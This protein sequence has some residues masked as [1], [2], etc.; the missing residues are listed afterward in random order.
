MLVILSLGE[1]SS[2]EELPESPRIAALR[3]AAPQERDGATRYFWDA[4]SKGGTP[5]VDLLEGGSRIRVT[6]VLRAPVPAGSSDDESDAA[7]R[8]SGLIGSFVPGGSRTL[9]RFERVPGTDVLQ[10]SFVLDARSRYRYYLAWPQGRQPDA[11]AVSRLELDGL[12][13]ELFADPLASRSFLDDF[14]GRAVRNSYFEGPS[15]PPEPWLDRRE[16]TARGEVT[17]LEVASRILANTRKVSIYA[18][19]G[20]RSNGGRAKDGSSGARSGAAGFPFVLLFDREAYLQS[21]PTA[22]ILDHLIDGKVIPPLFVIFVSP[23]DEAHRG[24][25]LPPNP[26]FASFIA[27][28]LVPQIRRRWPVSRDPRR[29]IV[30]G[31][32][33]GGLAAANI[34]RLHP[35][36]FGN[37]LSMSGSYWWHPSRSPN[38]D[39]VASDAESG[40]LPRQYA[41]STRLPLRFYLCVGLGEGDGML[42]PNR[43]FRDVLTAKGYA[44]RYDEFHGDHS[45]LNW[46]DSL[47]AGLQYL[48]ESVP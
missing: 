20:F 3:V 45:Y 32:S 23:I 15:A 40:W 36:V 33:Y 44:L 24:V 41:A 28:E 31:S 27:D 14:G 4:V 39:D 17:T 34:A 16:S 18:P 26:A 35:R 47:V 37:V 1:V 10:K 21:V 7:L 43:R 30:A 48:L 9:A 11:Q 12:G 25:E 46:R 5:L 38:D 22:A 6:F 29:A 19:P 8:N 42:A 13:Y 2:A